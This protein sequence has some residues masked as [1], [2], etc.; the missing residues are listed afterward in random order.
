MK[1]IRI[2]SALLALAVL[3]ALVILASTSK[4]GVRAVYASSGCTDS[5]LTG[6]YGFM[7]QGFDVLQHGTGAQLPW[8]SA[9][10][11]TFDGL[12]DVSATSVTGSIGGVIYQDQP[13]TSGTYTVTSGCTGSMSD[14]S[15]PGAGETLNM[16][17][18]GGGT[19]VFL[20]STTPTQTFVADAKKQ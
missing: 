6:N 8:A 16:V 9:G 10:V 20:I 17:I 11:L 3:A 4:H 14:T 18:V 5:T 19:E 15:G 1:R 13:A 2:V 12:G 7:W